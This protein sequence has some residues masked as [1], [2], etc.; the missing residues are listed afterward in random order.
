V[1]LLQVGDPADF[2]IFDNPKQFNIQKVVING[3]VVAEGGESYILPVEETPINAFNTSK[4]TTADI[5]VSPLSGTIKVIDII[6]NE[7]IT[8]QSILSATIVNGKVVSDI[9]N[10][11]LK[12]VMLNRYFPAKPAVAF[13]RYSGL[14]SGA[15]ASSI[16]HDSHNI[17]CVGTNDIDIVAAINA[18]IENR[19]GISASQNGIIN[20]VPLPFGGLMNN[21]S[22]DTTS[23]DY[24]KL[25]AKAK[26]MGS[27][28]SSPFSTLSF[29]GLL[30]I[31]ELKLSDKGLFDGVKFEFTNLFVED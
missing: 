20:I 21:Q 9:K 16:V 14:K 2:I 6:P 15:I 29:M 7:L 17:I 19:G 31:P 3:E 30:V 25:D 1:G 24:E 22:A 5:E 12:I 27:T 26:E 13:I 28:L 11:V 4:I 8:K 10:D 18:I 23:T